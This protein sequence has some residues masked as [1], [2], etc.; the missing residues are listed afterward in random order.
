MCT[1]LGKR[2][3]LVKQGCRLPSPSLNGLCWGIPSTL[4][5]ESEDCIL[6]A[7]LLCK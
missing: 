4:P 7:V 2:R 3:E 6:L 5:L 1:S